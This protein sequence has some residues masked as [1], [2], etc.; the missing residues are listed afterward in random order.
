MTPTFLSEVE[1][2]FSNYM[3]ANQ[4]AIPFYFENSK[5]PI[6]L[7]IYAVLHILP[8][9]DVLPIN[10]GIN[11][12][13]RNVGL[14]QVDVYGPKDTGAVATQTLAYQIGKAFKRVNL[15]V[16]TE[17]HAVF[18]DPSVQSR[19]EVRGRHKEQMRV[20]YRYDFK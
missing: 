7:D 9:E 12:K 13:S 5:V 4:A 1:A 6:D 18:K 10:V 19:G 17:G 11:A 2:L 14:I 3:V 16:A 8:S 15:L 20:P